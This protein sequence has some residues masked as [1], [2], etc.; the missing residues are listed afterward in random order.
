MPFPED[1]K[2]FLKLLNSHDVEYLLVGGYA[3]AYH[4]YIRATH[5]ID[6]WIRVTP[7]NVRRVVD[8]VTEFGFA[9]A[10]LNQEMFLKEDQVIRMGVPPLRIEVL[11]SISGVAFEECYRK[12]EIADMGDYQ[13]P[14]ISRDMLIKNKRASGRLKDLGDVENLG[15]K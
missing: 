13:I 8:A 14:I 15:R 4:G 12:R 6:V 11:T 9:P 2:D 5:D 1:F 3:V 10:D 7:E